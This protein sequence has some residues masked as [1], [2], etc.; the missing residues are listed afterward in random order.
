MEMVVPRSVGSLGSLE[1]SPQVRE[2]KYV[3]R[4]VCMCLFKWGFDWTSVGHGGLLQHLKGAGG[5]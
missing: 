1:P 2:L 4:S 5:D 3:F